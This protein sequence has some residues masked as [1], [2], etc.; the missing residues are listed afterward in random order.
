MSK[1]SDQFG[2]RLNNFYPSPPEAYEPL[3][4]FL[5]DSRI[6]DP[7]AGDG[8]ALGY[9]RDR[10][11]EIALASDLDPQ[12]AGIIAKDARSYTFED[13]DKY[14]IETFITNPPWPAPE[15][16]GGATLTLAMIRVLSTLRPTWLLLPADM[17]HTSYAPFTLAYCP[18]IVSI[19]RV[20][21]IPGSKDASKDNCCWYKFVGQ[22]VERTVFV[23]RR[24]R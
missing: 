10:G 11:H 8:R 5:E 3:F 24:R 18:L 22:K 9:L 13:V 12:A 14:R 16:E 23:N 2:R 6:C 19:G 4:P 15:G 7:C 21:W 1:R 20:K 17:M